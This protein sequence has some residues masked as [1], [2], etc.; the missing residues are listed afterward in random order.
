MGVRAIGGRVGLHYNQVAKWR[1]SYLRGG[2]GAL[3]GE[4]RSG[5]KGK[6]KPEAWKWV[7][8]P[9]AITGMSSCCAKFERGWG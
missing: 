4:P 6:H 5:R 1:R 3:Q 8:W 7:K 2:I 9:A